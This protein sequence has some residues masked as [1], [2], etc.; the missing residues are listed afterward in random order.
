MPPEQKTD[1]TTSPDTL[2]YIQQLQK[3]IEL[4]QQAK[5]LIQHQLQ[6]EQ[7]KRINTEGELQQ[8]R[9]ELNLSL[10]K[11]AATACNR[12]Q[13]K[14]T[15]T[16]NALKI[17]TEKMEKQKQQYERKVAELSEANNR[18]IENTKQHLIFV[19]EKIKKR[20]QQY[21]HD[22]ESAS[23]EAKKLRVENDFLQKQVQ[24]LHEQVTKLEQKLEEKMYENAE[25]RLRLRIPT[26]DNTSFMS[27]ITTRLDHME[28]SLAN[29]SHTTP[30]STTV[31][32][33]QQQ[34]FPLL[35]TVAT[36][37]GVV[38]LACVYFKR[39]V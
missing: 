23:E 30:N 13:Q 19:S 37:T 8:L 24:D 39:S 34:P 36:L 27:V 17:V 29:Q 35:P 22:I 11:R 20:K 10:D 3:Q 7:E 6:I 16:S 9:E 32:Q 18:I 21:L 4:E 1:N 15:K 28:K 2:F 26:D 31:I 25:L 12:L 38:A 14:L 33:S 5:L